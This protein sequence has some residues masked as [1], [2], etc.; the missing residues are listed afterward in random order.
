VLPAGQHEI[1]E[2]YSTQELDNVI[3]ITT[4]LFAGSTSPRGTSRFFQ[5]VAAQS[6]KSRYFERSRRHA[7]SNFVHG[8]SSSLLI[9]TTGW[10]FV[11]A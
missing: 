2:A 3:L 7:T 11:V 8:S 6:G 5:L 1:A 10:P 9:C 4:A